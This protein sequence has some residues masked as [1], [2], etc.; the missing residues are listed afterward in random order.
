MG[1]RHPHDGGARTARTRAGTRV[2]RRRALR[3]RHARAV[4]ARAT[5]TDGH[6][7]PRPR[8]IDDATEHADARARARRAYERAIT[9]STRSHERHA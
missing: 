4:L 2:A 8:D 9:D 6:T 1:T 5:D 7:R 3:A